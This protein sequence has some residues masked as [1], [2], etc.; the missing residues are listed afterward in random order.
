MG[1]AR[2]S[3][4]QTG[5][6]SHPKP[7]ATDKLKQPDKR[8]ETGSNPKP[9]ATDKL[10]FERGDPPPY[11]FPKEEVPFVVVLP[12]VGKV[13]P[14]EALD[15]T[16]GTLWARRMRLGAQVVDV[17]FCRATKNCSCGGKLPV[18]M[19]FL[20]SGEI[21]FTA[22]H[23]CPL[24]FDRHITVWSLTASKVRVDPCCYFCKMRS[25]L[26]LMLVECEENA[27]HQIL[28]MCSEC[29]RVKY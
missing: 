25:T 28:I 7:P 12:L 10:K 5:G 16:P 13:Y 21:C 9:P 18:P 11:E 14:I 24:N 27:T 6:A 29:L 2:A 4:P 22:P 26:P 1:G 23:L 3:K 8:P 17:P 15:A 20:R 19:G